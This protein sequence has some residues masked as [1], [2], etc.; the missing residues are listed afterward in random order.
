M[1]RAFVFKWCGNTGVKLYRAKINILIKFKAKFQ[2]NAFFEDTRFY[3]RMT[4]SP[5]E[6]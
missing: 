2:E 5:Q 1:L 6:N 4:D 3:F